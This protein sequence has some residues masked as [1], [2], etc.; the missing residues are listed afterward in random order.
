MNNDEKQNK[1]ENHI[2]SKNIVIPVDKGLTKSIIEIILFIFFVFWCVT[3]TE[4]VFSIADKI[5]TLITPFTLGLCIAFVLNTILCPLENIWTKLTKRCKNKFK[6]KAKRPVCL[7]L[8]IIIAF[9]AIFAIIFMLIPEII[10]TAKELFNL[11]P[12]I[13]TRVQGWWTNIMDLLEQYDINLPEL[14]LNSSKLMEKASEIIS[15]YGSSVI[16]TTVSISTS[17]VTFLVNFVLASVF[18]IYLLAQKE[19]IGHQLRKATNVF[20]PKKKTNSL[21]KILALANQSFTKFVVGQLVEAVIIG[22]LCFFGMIIF[23]MPY[24][25]I[26]SVLVGFTALIPV[27]GAFIGTAVGAFLILIKDPMQAV[28]F[29]VF[30]LVLQ[31]IE[32]NLI[33]P[34]VVG[35]SVGLPGILVLIAVTIGGGAMGFTGM[36]FSVPICSLLYSLSQELIEKR[37]KQK[38]AASIYVITE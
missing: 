27:F 19:H 38:H 13:F 37:S 22:V 12:T 8:S 24:A 32:G 2:N 4:K 28:W 36:L 26:V 30:I 25:G 3:N 10:N 20:L 23:N 5:L 35:K 1:Q 9:G 33:Y 31:Q 14:N 11:M 21:F 18:A 7:L 16:S 6:D 17:I 15:S 34:K 29:V